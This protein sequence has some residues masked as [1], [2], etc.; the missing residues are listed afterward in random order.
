MER[1]Q[2]G[3]EQVEV[4]SIS[5]EGVSGDQGSAEQIRQS[6]SCSQ[7]TQEIYTTKTL[8]VLTQQQ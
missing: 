7:P 2:S 6:V 1:Q 3:R 4:S 8:S 5:T